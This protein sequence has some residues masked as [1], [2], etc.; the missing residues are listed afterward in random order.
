[1]R[2]PTVSHSGFFAVSDSSGDFSKKFHGFYGWDTRFLSQLTLEIEGYK[3]KPL[4]Y[5]SLAPWR[6]IFWIERNGVIIARDRTIDEDG[7]LIESF[8]LPQGERD[9]KLSLSFKV[10]FES[11]FEV[12]GSRRLPRRIK[13][14]NKENSITYTYSGVD[15]LTRVLKISLSKGS[16]QKDSISITLKPGEKAVVRFSPSLSRKPVYMKTPA[17]HTSLIQSI[18]TDSEIF[19]LVLDKSISDLSSLTYYTRYGPVFLAGIPYFACVFGRDSIISA[20]Y[21]LPYYPEYALSTLKLL[22]E[23]QGRKFDTRKEEEPGKIPH[24]VRFD[25]LSLAGITPFSTYYGTVDAT[26][27]YVILAREYLKWSGDRNGIKTVAPYLKKAVEWILDKIEENGFLTYSPRPG[28]LVNQGWKDSAEGVPYE[29]G[30]PV[31]PPV[32]LIEVQGYAYAALQGA[33]EM[34]DILGLD[35]NYLKEEARSLYDRINR[36]F[37]M[38]DRGY[39]ALALDGD[40]RKSSVLASNQGHLL[41]TTAASRK[42]EIVEK[43]FSPRLYSGWGIRTLAEGEKAYNPFS[44]HNGSV[45]PHDNAFISL[46]LSKRGFTVQ[47]SRLALDLFEAGYL[48]DGFPELFS[49][50]SRSVGPPCPVSRANIPQAWSAASA[51]ALVTSFLALEVEDSILRVSPVLPRG[52]GY[53][54]LRV[55]AFGREG[56]LEVSGREERAEIRVSNS[57]KVEGV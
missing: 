42:G 52:V 36:Y 4:S 6:M 27:L 45:W 46:G 7:T 17:P 33:A 44:Y 5:V 31:K 41:F 43:I 48:L 19:S 25:E 55:K 10:D 32:A 2:E 51:Y 18:K 11:I 47:A 8:S 50:L 28:G 20:L 34:A 57:I 29:N 35:V 9:L 53:V 22:G 1:M 37:W 39:Y 38:E 21:V 54:K 3:P 24:E 30:E 40:G 14:F 49:G 13:H 15:G 23:L 12:R 16:L 56:F 26:P